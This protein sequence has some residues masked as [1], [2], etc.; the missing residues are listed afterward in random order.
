M[1]NRVSWAHP[2]RA[3]FCW[4]QVGQGCCTSGGS[5]GHPVKN[6]CSKHRDESKFCPGETSRVAALGRKGGVEA[7]SFVSV[8]YIL[9]NK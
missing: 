5:D 8:L 9:L 2:R 1:R 3:W 7:P 6:F 4:P